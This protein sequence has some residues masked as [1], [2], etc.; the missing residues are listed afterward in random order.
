MFIFIFLIYF[1]AIDSKNFIFND[2]K[3]KNKAYQIKPAAFSFLSDRNV[4]LSEITINIENTKYKRKATMIV[5]N[6]ICFGSFPII[7]LEI[8]PFGKL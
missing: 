3:L 1:Y 7:I 5:N 6:N 2:S 8:N 4:E